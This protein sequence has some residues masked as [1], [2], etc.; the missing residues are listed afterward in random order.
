M[1][2]TLHNHHTSASV[3]RK[4]CDLCFV[5]EIDMTPGSNNEWLEL[6]NWQAELVNTGESLARTR[7]KSW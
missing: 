7:A 6:T 3:G 1:D 2:D 4:P 5:Y